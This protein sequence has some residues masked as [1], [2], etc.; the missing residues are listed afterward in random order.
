MFNRLRN[1][2]TTQLLQAL[3]RSEND[4]QMLDSHP[5]IE[6]ASRR[7]SQAVEVIADLQF[8]KRGGIP[9]TS[10]KQIAQYEDAIGLL[11]EAVTAATYELILSQN[12]PACGFSPKAKVRLGDTRRKARG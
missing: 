10:L 8:T 7:V 1:R 6:V 5:L 9:R 11:K 4:V 12:C 3:T 2:S